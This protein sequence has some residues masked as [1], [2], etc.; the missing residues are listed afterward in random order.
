MQPNARTAA[1]FAA[2]LSLVLAGCGPS[3]PAVN[4]PPRSLTGYRLVYRVETH[5]PDVQVTRREVAVLRP[6]SSSDLTYPDGGTDPT[7]GFVSKG[8]RLYSVEKGAIVDH[9]DR[10]SGSPPGDDRLGAVIA[11]LVRLHLARRVGTARAA[12]RACVVYRLAGPVG[13][14]VKPIAAGEHADECIDGSG[15]VL[16]ERWELHGRL[17]RLTEAVQ[18]DTQAPPAGAFEPPALPRHPTPTGF[19]DVTILPTSSTPKTG[20]PY[21]DSSSPPWGFRL[22][23]RV[24][25]ATSAITPDGPQVS[26][27]EYVDTYRRGPD[28]ITVA[29]RE[30]TLESRSEGSDHVRAGRL[31][32]GTVTFGS[33][34]ADLAFAAGKWVVTVE[35]PFDVAHLRVFAG[36]LLPR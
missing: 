17:V 19:T 11:D 31:G 16:A 22:V 20:L 9:G 28:V 8:T 35:G 12:G 33:G 25:A 32:R 10:P 4:A 7:S 36:T 23:R 24:R 15:L 5:A 13:D 6:D 2:G 3:V 30:Q 34:G 1:S 21:W 18:V 29:H 14:P 27:I 26:D